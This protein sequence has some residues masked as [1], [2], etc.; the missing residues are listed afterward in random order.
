MKMDL[1]KGIAA[2]IYNHLNLPK[3]ITFSNGG[4]IEYLYTASGTKLRK[5]VTSGTTVQ[6]TEYISGYQYEGGVL[7]FSRRP[8]A[9]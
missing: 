8:R 3:T 5:T 2:I 1:N 7:N 6:T 4:S 9:M